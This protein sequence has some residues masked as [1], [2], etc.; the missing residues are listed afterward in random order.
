MIVIR[1]ILQ[2]KNKGVLFNTIM[3]NPLERSEKFRSSV[4]S[5]N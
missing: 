3:S 2:V 1:I 5:R 4:N